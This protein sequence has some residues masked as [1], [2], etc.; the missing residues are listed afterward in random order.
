MF[1][2]TQRIIGATFLT[3]TFND[4]NSYTHAL[5]SSVYLPLSNVAIFSEV[6]MDSEFHSSRHYLNQ[7]ERFSLGVNQSHDG[8]Q[9]AWWN[10]YC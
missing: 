10:L 7:E 3:P 5:T 6:R 8:V 9:P 4:N 2:R 1:L